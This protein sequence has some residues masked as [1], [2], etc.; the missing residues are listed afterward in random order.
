MKE[1]FGHAVY[2]HAVPDNKIYG[3]V[4]N[5]NSDRAGW[6]SWSFHTD[7]YFNIYRNRI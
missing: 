1:E 6:M 2:G 4:Q 3:I 5:D 7:L